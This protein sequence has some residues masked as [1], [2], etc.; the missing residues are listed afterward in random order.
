MR[1]TRSDA[2]SQRQA[3]AG[4]LVEPIVKGR[5]PQEVEEAMATSMVG[6]RAYELVRRRPPDATLMP[7]WLELAVRVVVVGSVAFG[8]GF[9]AVIASRSVG[10]VLAG[11]PGAVLA[12]VTPVLT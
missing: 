9:V 5:A 8:A 4:R 6:I 12:T 3:C 10:W 11:G 2:A 1:V 7:V